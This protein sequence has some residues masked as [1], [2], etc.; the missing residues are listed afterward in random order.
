MASQEEILL[1]LARRTSVRPCPEIV[2]KKHICC[3]PEYQVVD[4]RHEGEEFAVISGSE[5]LGSG[6]GTGVVYTLDHKPVSLGSVSG[7]V[8]VGKT[9]RQIIGGGLGAVDKEGFRELTLLDINT[10]E[11]SSTPITSAKINYTTGEIVTTWDQTSLLTDRY[12]SIN[13]E[14]EQQDCINSEQQQLFHTGKSPYDLT[15]P[16][17]WGFVL[18]EEPK[19][20]NSVTQERKM[21]VYKD[22]V[23]KFSFKADST[24]NSGVGQAFDQLLDEIRNVEQDE[25]PIWLTSPPEEGGVEDLIIS[26]SDS[27]IPPGQPYDED[28]LA[29]CEFEDYYTFT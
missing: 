28:F 3:L 22:G 14:W 12:V 7:R 9:H 6:S 21:N 20:S 15:N 16:L 19:S 4:E 5:A 17:P 11:E 26:V 1:E 13:Y 29:S 2:W 18:S 8:V 23:C 25:L 10:E 24:D 27:V